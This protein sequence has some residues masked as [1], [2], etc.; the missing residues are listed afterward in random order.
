M[1]DVRLLPGPTLGGPDCPRYVDMSLWTLRLCVAIIQ[2]DKLAQLALP[3]SSSAISF[4][5]R[6]K[7]PTCS[8]PPAAGP[9]PVCFMNADLRLPPTLKMWCPSV[10][11]RVQNRRRM[12]FSGSVCERGVVQ[13]P[14]GLNCAPRQ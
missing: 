2:G 6:R 14:A 1:S 9:L 8:S 12:H 3:R 5:P 4:E 10:P 13:Q 11:W 7:V